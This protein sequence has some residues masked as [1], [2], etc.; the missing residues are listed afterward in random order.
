MQYQKE[1]Q[2]E[3]AHKEYDE[4]FSI[5]VLNLSQETG[6]PPTAELLKYV[7]FKNH[8]L[9]LLKELEEETFV[10]QD[11]F[12]DRVDIIVDEF[13]E[14]LLYD[15]EEESFL[16]LLYLICMSLKYYRIARI[17]LETII[18]SP[19]R[20]HSL[21][22]AF[23]SGKYLSPSEY[24]IIK[25]YYAL[26]IKLNDQETFENQ[27]SLAE[28]AL[29]LQ[30]TD[31][32]YEKVDDLSWL[33]R[34]SEPVLKKNEFI[35]KEAITIKSSDWL[36][37][38]RAVQDT[39][40]NLATKSKR[41][42]N[43][44]DP[45]VT[46]SH[47]INSVIIK[48]PS[49]EPADTLDTSNIA[50]VKSKSD[51]ELKDKSE[52][53]TAGES[54]EEE[55]GGTYVL[56]TKAVEINGKKPISSIRN[57]EK[58]DQ[59][60]DA[61]ANET[62]A[63]EQESSTTP[64]TTHD[65]GIK[66]ED[67][68]SAHQP[69]LG[70]E[71]PHDNTPSSEIVAKDNGKS[72]SDAE[73]D[74]EKPLIVSSEPD[75]S[76]CKG[77][78]LAFDHE[79]MGPKRRRERSL[80]DASR[81]RSSKR[82]KARGD[83]KCDLENVDLTE[84]ENFF[85]Q[86]SSFLELCNLK[87][88][89]VIPIFLKDETSSKDMFISDF[90]YI[91]QNWN[92]ELG[93]V[94]NQCEQDASTKSNSKKPLL[95]Q[96]IDNSDDSDDLNSQRPNTL[97]ASPSAQEFIEVANNNK[98]HIQELRIKLARKLLAPGL[99][100]NSI[101]VSELLP[102]T[103]IEL[104]KKTIE[105]CET[106]MG[107]IAKDIVRSA[108]HNEIYSEIYIVQTI[109]EIIV[110]TIL[111]ANKILRSP[112]TQS[113]QLLREMELIRSTFPSRFQWWSRTFS[114]L[115]SIF[116]KTDSRLNELILRYEL[117]NALYLQANCNESWDNLD[118]LLT[119]E[120][121]IH[122]VDS[123]ISFSFINLQHF[124]KLS[125]DSIRTQIAKQKAMSTLSKVF[126]GGDI[127]SNDIENLASDQETHRSTLNARVSLLECVLMPDYKTEVPIEYK[128]ISDYFVNAPNTLRSQFW[129][130][131]LSDYFSIGE[132]EKSLN[133]Y[134]KILSDSISEI[135]G[136]DYL[137]LDAQ[138]RYKNILKVMITSRETVN[139]IV[140][141]I[142]SDENLLKKISRDSLKVYFVSIIQLLRTLHIFILFE[143][144]VID[145]IFPPVTLQ[146]WQSFSLYLKELLVCSWCLFYFLFKN[147][148]P[149]ENK[150]P[151]ILNDLLSIIHEQLGTRGYC[152]LADGILLD[153]SLHEIHTIQFSESDA[154]ILQCLHC[155]FGVVLGHEYYHPYD[156]QTTPIDLDAKNAMIYSGFLMKNVLRKKNLAQ[157]ILRTDVKGALDAFYESLGFPD[158]SISAIEK[159][160]S[161]MNN[162]LNSSISP[163]FLQSCFKGTFS[164]EITT[165]DIELS[166]LSKTGFYYIM[167]QSRMSLFKIRKRTLP[168]HT[169]DIA[170]AVKFFKYDLICG[171]P[172]RYES[173]YALSQGYDALVEDDLTWN[174]YKVNTESAREAVGIRQ[175]KAIISCAIAL[176]C[177]LRYGSHPLFEN[178]PSF[179]NMIGPAS[180]FF[181]RLLYNSV[182][183]PLNM[184]AYASDGDK[185]LCGAD[186]LYTKS[187]KFNFKPA[188]I[189]KCA[190]FAL[191]IATT[192]LPGDWFN[193]FLKGKCMTQ[194][195]DDPLKILD[196][197]VVAIDCC[198]EKPGSHG[199]YILEPHYK[200][201]SKVYKF[202]RDDKISI[203]TAM[204]YLHKTQYY[205]DKLEDINTGNTE[206]DRIF[207]ICI[208]TLVKI[209]SN[210]RKKTQHR[211]T[212]RIS[213]IYEDCGDIQKA[214]EEINVFFQLKS[215]SKVPINIWKTDFERPGQHFH[216]VTQYIKYFITLLEKT[217]D[218]DMLGIL[219]KSLRKF[220]SGMIDHQATW[221]FLCSTAT[222]I[223]RK[224]L[225]LPPKYNDQIIPHLLYDDFEA[226][227]TKI[228]E[229]V[230]KSE[231]LHPKL[232]YLN[233]IAEIRRLNNGFGSTAA[234][235]DV[236]VASFL[237]IYQDFVTNILKVKE[238]V[239][240]EQSLPP[241][242][243]ISV[244]D[245]LS[246]PTTPTSKPTSPAN[247]ESTNSK[248]PPPKVRVTRRD[249][250]SR[251]LA[252]LRT[253]LPKLM[254]G[255]NSK[256]GGGCPDNTPSSNPTPAETPTAPSTPLLKETRQVTPQKLSVSMNSNGAQV[257]SVV[258]QNSRENTEPL[259]TQAEETSSEKDNLLFVSS[260]HP[261]P[262]VDEVI[263]ISPK[264]TKKTSSSSWLSTIL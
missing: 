142:R 146:S 211:P 159:N 42:I 64:D 242:T 169:E 16:E 24:R 28:N 51:V 124:P 77:D 4:L 94:V 235:D 85:S 122:D 208:S 9:L 95:S 115:A 2:R 147:Y 134:L 52:D 231:Q 253:A 177:F 144:G 116:N 17:C 135:T 130:L 47:A 204:E 160:N 23:E 83:E 170:E 101:F 192:E 1:G 258:V 154:D 207:G 261:E 61:R 190:L 145:G 238:P 63:Q 241:P 179:Q 13:S 191:Q 12:D 55:N 114:D 254:K 225:E 117:T 66:L 172:N 210:D 41:K 74:N 215:S 155:R 199:E 202:V 103:S 125:L 113:K 58:T 80:E 218:L 148:I 31:P 150:D 123:N 59:D 203:D 107:D 84:D 229:Y 180:A 49:T 100:S 195:K 46:S 57:G 88:D 40:V 76:S 162:L 90:K 201:V 255:D 73:N 11:E 221:E 128:T 194:L 67:T 164:P 181:A 69:N 54:D 92:E 173:W 111:Q 224:Q 209:R 140:E 171:S 22:E 34:R 251:A 217:E 15:S 165:P 187:K 248:A 89:S 158:H 29:S 81:S 257:S 65:C 132:N 75:K 139:N 30:F 32:K 37:I 245:L 184:V 252:I 200:L 112:E 98:F 91:I 250:I 163:E 79:D 109:L 110:D 205:D 86:I 5:E 188:T 198:P 234:L 237:Q 161:S 175:R 129:S 212:Y 102:S 6:L 93:K 196:A 119:L 14:A 214:K 256:L 206:K 19:A 233:Y 56:D 152:G 127:K 240:K 10:E 106:Q 108:D 120:N 186:G 48:L 174:I 44:E 149:E 33:S 68:T 223:V 20:T 183:E 222:R 104:L 226:N 168:G 153:I 82:V 99:D 71:T 26:L 259:S 189:L 232:K 227:F 36:S 213:K 138:S 72:I 133:G 7:A 105:Q 185:L 239:V 230:E 182:Q 70:S 126:S 53:S 141:L 143:D 137:S 264:V 50:E 87:F 178:T 260:S 21:L 156:H 197:F 45:Y 96:L 136:D 262:D 62:S 3:K 228:T 216:Y 220:T 193:Y 38:L 35:T 151:E 43:I 167:G 157:N 121:D 18:D 97:D 176:N 219:S 249:I 118:D 246:Q 25:N 78:M 263:E 27:K 236:F 244:M 39:V 166:H 60:S 131:L 243:K 8:G 247:N